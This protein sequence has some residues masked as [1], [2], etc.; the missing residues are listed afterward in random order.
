MV[1][2]GH[3]II[4]LHGQLKLTGDAEALLT[5]YTIS[6]D[7]AFGIREWVSLHNKDS[8]LEL[9][10]DVKEPKFLDAEF[11]ELFRK[12]LDA[13]G[14]VRLSTPL[15]HFALR[16]I[17]SAKCDDNFMTVTKELENFVP[18]EVALLF[19][20]ARIWKAMERSY[21]AGR[22]GRPSGLIELTS[23]LMDAAKSSNDI[24]GAESFAKY[25]KEL[26]GTW[27]DCIR[28]HAKCRRGP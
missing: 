25:E 1:R 24:R 21:M 18:R 2:I 5:T 17:H 4:A 27:E 8:T 7:C 22:E 12:E 11:Q 10:H 16:V 19:S 13:V 9:K 6:G 3:W 26:Q 14:S 20:S 23:L 28:W 15:Q